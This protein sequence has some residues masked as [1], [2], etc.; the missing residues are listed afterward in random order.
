MGRFDYQQLAE[1][2]MYKLLTL[3]NKESRTIG[4]RLLVQHLMNQ[5]RKSRRSTEEELDLSFILNLKIKQD[6][7]YYT[8]IYQ[9]FEGKKRFQFGLP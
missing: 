3:I 7:T 8:D 1:G 4:V 9:Q 5:F 6:R 2:W